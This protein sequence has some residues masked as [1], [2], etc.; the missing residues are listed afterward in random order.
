M[1][2][3]ARIVI[4][5]VPHHITQRGN[6]Q[7]PIFF[8]EEDYRAYIEILA[9][10]LTRHGTRCLAWCLM[11]NHV[12][13]MLVPATEDGLRATLASAHTTYAQRINQLQDTS[14]HLFQ[15]R[16]ASYA[17]DDAHM[18]VAARYIE[19]NPVKAGMVKRAED[20][21]WSS[22]RAHISG[23]GDWLTDIS[24]LGQ[25]LPNWAAMLANGLEAAEQVD[26]AIRTGRPLG[27]ADWLRQIGQGEPPKRRGRP[28]R[29]NK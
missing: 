27:T 19:T 1:P 22:A 15:G 21:L 10:A 9:L 24:A 17:M 28:S 5:G 4:P 11:P 18:M 26:L 25:H 20:W 14:G 23:D 6:R 7:Q 29:L 13:L 12:H 16:F 3:A 2:R 8:S